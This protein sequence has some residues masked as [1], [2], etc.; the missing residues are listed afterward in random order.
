MQMGSAL[1]KGRA[2]SGYTDGTHPSA[3]LLAHEGLWEEI[4]PPGTKSFSG[5][6]R[7]NGKPGHFS[8]YKIGIAMIARSVSTSVVRPLTSVFGRIAGLFL[9]ALA[10]VGA[11]AQTPAAKGI[12]DTWQGTLKLAQRDLRT[13]IKIAKDDK[14]ALK[15]TFYSI[16]QGAGSIGASTMG[17]EG[18]TLKVS[19]D[20]LQ[21]T[22]EGR[23]SADGTT[24]TGTVTQDGKPNPLVLERATAATA[25]TIPEPPKRIPAMPADAKPVFDVVTVK[26]SDPNQKGMGFTLR[27]G[28]MLTINTTLQDILE[29]AYGVQEK[30]LVGL[31]DWATKDKFDIDGKPDIEG[32]PSIKQSGNMLQHLLADRFG[33]KV[34]ED[35]K[36]MSAYVLS[37]AKGGVKIKPSG[38]KPD[39]TPGLGFRGLG[40]LVVNDATLTEFADLM[41]QAV[42]DRPVVD[43]TGLEGR[44]SFVLKWTPDESQFHGQLAQMPKPA[45]TA[46]PP[47]ALYTAIT[48]QL[49]LKL[50]AGKAPVRVIVIDHIEK[51]SAN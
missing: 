41:A 7:L 37:A 10:L 9:F 24:I 22:Y 27:G 46:D 30:Q 45:E 42:L 51:P 40:V 48:E 44:F 16:D 43:Q 15:G 13:V 20:M 49:G 38:A 26:L 2:L 47:P 5:T 17:F 39:A 8:L 1:A 35:K 4:S 18:G 6:Y 11:S 36:D 29:F 23:I 3:V 31:P 50:D 34:H 28:H 21:L 19:I 32:L 12:E 25:W 33:M 14:G